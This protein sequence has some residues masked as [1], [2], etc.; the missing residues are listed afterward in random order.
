MRMKTIFYSWQSDLPNAANRSFIEGCLEKAIKELHVEGSLEVEA[1]IDR[2]TA[3]VPGSPDIVQTIFDKIDKAAMFVGDVS[4]INGCKQHESKGCKCTRQTPNPNV[5][6][7]LG[8]AMKSIGFDRIAC[9]FNEATG[10][11]GDLP[12][13][14]RNRRIMTYRLAGGED[15][16]EQRKVLT[17]KLKGAIDEILKIP[18]DLVA[19]AEATANEYNEVIAF[20][21]EALPV[22]DKAAW[23]F[24]FRPVHAKRRWEER[25]DL[26]RVIEKHAIRRYSTF[27][28]HQGMHPQEWG[29]AY[30]K[31]RSVWALNHSGLFVHREA[32]AENR[33]TWK[34]P[35][36]EEDGTQKTRQP[37]TWIDFKPS[38]GRLTEYFYFLSRYSAEFA[39]SSEIE[40]EFRVEPLSGKVLASS[41]GN[42]QVSFMGPSTE[43]CRAKKFVHR[44]KMTAEAFRKG[45]KDHCA[46]MMREFFGYFPD[47]R[48]GKETL[49]NWIGKIFG[50]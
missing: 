8:R 37:G 2:D 28:P 15:K 48:I 3:G 35:W 42:V 24:F 36:L 29:I 39:P 23:T 7:E 9:V 47:T 13:D 16:A 27:P 1:C 50:S 5:A 43:E 6:I 33:S 18:E 45:W 44:Q 34:S 40:Y 17:A 41:D 12:F 4:F 46:T 30:D 22:E 10:N 14:L 19:G 21:D 31:F 11:I 26:E 25:E 20:L 49:L 38:I 32:L